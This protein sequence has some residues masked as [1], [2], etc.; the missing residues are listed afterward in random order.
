M[1]T[2]P[3]SF[4]ELLERASNSFDESFKKASHSFDES[5]KQFQSK[6]DEVVGNSNP[7]FLRPNRNDNRDHS[8][9]L[10]DAT[11]IPNPNPG[12]GSEKSDNVPKFRDYATD[13]TNS[14][15][16][17]AYS[18]CRPPQRR[19]ST[20]PSSTL[21]IRTYAKDSPTK[22][23]PMKRSSSTSSSRKPFDEISDSGNS[24][25][26]NRGPS[27]EEDRLS[28]EETTDR[29]PTR[30]AKKTTI[31][32]LLGYRSPKRV[33]RSKRYM[34]QPVGLDFMTLNTQ[35]GTMLIVSMIEPTSIFATS[36]INVGDAILSI[37]GVSFGN[38][39]VGDNICKP[40]VE[41]ARKLLEKGWDGLP[42]DHRGRSSPGRRRFMHV[43]LEY[44]KF[45]GKD[46]QEAKHPTGQEY[47]GE[48]VKLASSHSAITKATDDAI[49]VTQDDDD[50]EKKKC[51]RDPCSSAAA[52]A[53]TAI[54][55]ESTTSLKERKSL[56]GPAKAFLNRTRTKDDAPSNVK[57]DFEKA[58]PE[59]VAP[60]TKAPSPS[61][62]IPPAPDNSTRLAEL[63]A[64]NHKL[65]VSG[66]L[67]IE[68]SKKRLLSSHIASSN[69]EKN[70]RSENQSCD[71]PDTL[72]KQLDLDKK[73]LFDEKVESIRKDL[74]SDVQEVR[75]TSRD[76][77]GSSNGDHSLTAKGQDA[78]ITNS[79]NLSTASNSFDWFEKATA[80]AEEESKV[81]SQKS[82]SRQYR[83]NAL[84]DDASWTT[85]ELLEEEIQK[86]N[87]AQLLGEHHQELTRL[88]K[89]ISD[90][91][92]SRVDLLKRH[93]MNLSKEVAELRLEAKNKESMLTNYQQQVEESKATEEN[94][95]NEIELYQSRLRICS[96]QSDKRQQ[97]LMDQLEKQRHATSDRVTLLLQRISDLERSNRKLVSKIQTIQSKRGPMDDMDIEL[98]Q[99]RKTVDSQGTRIRNLMD[100]NREIKKRNEELGRTLEEN[101][102]E[103]VLAEIAICAARS[104]FLERQVGYLT[105]QLKS[106][107]T[108]AR[109]ERDKR[110]WCQR[111]LEDA[112]VK[113]SDG[114]QHFHENVGSGTTHN[115]DGVGKG[116]ETSHDM[117]KATLSELE[118]SSQAAMVRSAK[119][120]PPNVK[121]ERDNDMEEKKTMEVG[122]Q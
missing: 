7:Y 35:M 68:E 75:K 122:E 52:A 14:R 44:R 97:E 37:N 9:T 26:Q 99:L 82:T 111:E 119:V 39:G 60:A 6:Y 117:A 93:N 10:V 65:R 63:R 85:V 47:S 104:S 32:N 43:T 95:R 109:E 91:L 89:K 15:E 5:F 34:T 57:E 16:A 67:Q 33:T 102:Q 25:L 90:K 38:G 116:A 21:P 118:S 49:Y 58:P 13:P 92:R 12:W 27:G 103:N 45:G 87:A 79:Q 74:L 53:V 3:T 73:D 54:T 88:N 64:R 2:V 56:W 80:E 1:E 120:K 55:S 24:I 84:L 108:E 59:V 28:D 77:L 62:T 41:I 29:P 17:A 86:S 50:D 100:A 94:L 106:A 11:V 105:E 69:K 31:D 48:A 101:C 113:L 18:N 4:H 42:R 70:F 19:K 8:T 30:P 46:V 96:L 51:V 72:E 110:L 83:A 23:G 76:S 114:M 20:K 66:N 112:L 115:T 22:D 61:P 121:M 98:K 107:K 78:L 71:S 36:G 40:D 81:S